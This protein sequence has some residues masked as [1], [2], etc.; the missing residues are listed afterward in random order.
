MAAVDWDSSF[1]ATPAGSDSPDTIDD[2]INELKEN[3]RNRLEKELNW[4]TGTPGQSAQGWT[5]KGSAHAYAQAAA[6]TQRPDASTAL[7]SDDAG[8]LWFDTDD[9]VL[10]VYDGS[11]WDL[12]IVGGIQEAGGSELGMLMLDIGDWDMDTDASVNVAHGITS[13]TIRGFQVLIRN[14]DGSENHPLNDAGTAY[15]DGTNFVLT[16]TGSGTFDDAAFDATSYNRG[17]IIIWYEA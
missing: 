2:K 3:L 17:W 12:P 7:S 16:R 4:S 14:D 11:S 9:D 8:R 6:P 1:E 15:F 5:K 13:T 10:K